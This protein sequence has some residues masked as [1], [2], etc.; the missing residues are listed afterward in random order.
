[1]ETTA[2]RHPRTTV[3]SAAQLQREISEVLT[4]MPP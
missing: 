1:M 4:K 2:G 3:K